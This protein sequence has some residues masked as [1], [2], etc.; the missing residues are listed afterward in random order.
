M[1][2]FNLSLLAVSLVALCAMKAHAAG[3]GFINY[4]K[5]QENYPF[6]IQAVK[7][8]D[9]KVLKFNSL[10]LIR[11]NSTRCLILR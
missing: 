5:V 2:K 9:A 6:A 1:K 10:W 4:Q 3:V 7:E 8:V 11:K